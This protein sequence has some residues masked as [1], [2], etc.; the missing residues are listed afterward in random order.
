MQEYRS[1]GSLLFEG[2]VIDGFSKY[3]FSNGQLASC[4]FYVQGKK[5]GEARSYSKDGKLMCLQNYEDG[6]FHGI[7]KF[8][9]ATSSLKTEL[10]YHKG[11]L[12][13]VFCYYP[14]GSLQ[15][16]VELE[17]GKRH[18]LDCFFEP[19]GDERFSFEYEENVLHRIRTADALEKAF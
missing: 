9:Y 17:K 8:F 11:F 19:T 10:H 18:G 14:D 3:Y 12:Q 1:N 15:R 16:R 13:N 5:E 7:Q 6:L 2:S 4:T